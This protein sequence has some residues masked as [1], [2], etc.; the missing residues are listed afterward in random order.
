LR[1]PCGLK[2]P[3]NLGVRH[4]VLPPLVI[5]VEDHPDPVLLGITKGIRTLRPVQPYAHVRPSLV[6]ERPWAFIF[7]DRT[8]A[9]IRRQAENGKAQASLVIAG[10]EWRVS[11]KVE[12]G[13]GA[14]GH[15]PCSMPAGIEPFPGGSRTST[16]V[17]QY[18]RRTRRSCC[19]EG[20]ELFAICGFPRSHDQ[21]QAER[22]VREKACPLLRGDGHRVRGGAGAGVIGLE[23]AD[24]AEPGKGSERCAGVRSTWLAASSPSSHRRRMPAD[25][26][27]VSRPGSS[28]S[29]RY[30]ERGHV[31]T[32]VTTSC[33][34]RKFGTRRERSDST[35]QTLRP[36]IKAANAKRRKAVFRRSPAA[37]RTTPCGVRSPR[38]CTKWAH[39]WRT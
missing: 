2:D 35:R 6:R 34:R 39:H 19:D 14:S 17:F 23:Q 30:V 7:L 9:A 24:T 8:I 37:S 36:A 4:E 26:C 13:R 29:R 25:A 32:G 27:S 28:R 20:R 16:L 21:C 33:S 11:G 31:T 22:P 18:R 15:F 5:P 1:E 12:K 38:C 10:L 3:R